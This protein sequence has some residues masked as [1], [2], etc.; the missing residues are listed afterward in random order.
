MDSRYQKHLTL[1]DRYT[2]EEGL[3][4]GYTLTRIAEEVG[5]DKSTISKEIRKHRIGN[6]QRIG[7]VN[8]C[9]N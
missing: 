7:N 3:N 1:Q 4:H 8:D 6:S 5:K 2:I 9:M